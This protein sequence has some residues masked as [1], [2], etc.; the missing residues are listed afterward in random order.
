MKHDFEIT[1]KLP[2]E[3]KKK[4]VEALRSGTYKQGKANLYEPK[5]CSYCCIGVAGKLCGIELNELSDEGYLMSD[6]LDLSNVPNM[7]QGCGDENALTDYLAF[8]NDN[9][10]TFEQIADWIDLNL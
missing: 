3:F 4:W 5:T 10:K 8:M 7:I 9:D 2:V 6:V 1:E